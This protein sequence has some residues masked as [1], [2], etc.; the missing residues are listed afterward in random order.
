MI[1]GRSNLAAAT[2]LS[3]AVGPRSARHRSRSWTPTRPGSWRICQ[4][5]MEGS[6]RS[7]AAATA[8]SS[9]WGWLISAAGWESVARARTTP[10]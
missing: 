2:L 6:W 9:R 10:G 3:V 5:A 1:L 4:E 8:K 7:H